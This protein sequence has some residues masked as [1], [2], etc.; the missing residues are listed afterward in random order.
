MYE[1]NLDSIIGGA[2]EAPA[3]EVEKEEVITLDDMLDG[4]TQM[5]MKHNVLS[6]VAGAISALTPNDEFTLMDIVLDAIGAD[7]EA[8]SIDEEAFGYATQ[9]TMDFAYALGMSESAVKDLFADDEMVAMDE[10]Q[11]FASAINEATHVEGDLA[12]LVTAH[13][14]M[15]SLIGQF[16]DEE[17]IEAG[18]MLDEITI[19]WAFSKTKSR[20][21][22]KTGTGH[23][24]KTVE[25]HRTIDGQSKKG[26][27][28][29]P[30]SLLSGKYKKA[31]GVS[32]KQKSHLAQMVTDAHT[33]V[34]QARRTKNMKL[35][36]G[37][38]SS[39][40]SK[41]SMAKA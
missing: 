20:K 28:R 16:A 19:D 27:C 3:V 37:G 1:I 26:F 21:K 5:H 18:V 2:V 24:M 38:R 33:S 40:V 11:N 15:D 4:M 29:Y 22:A 39:S 6:D 34:A 12:Q 25:C 41:A 8:D 30:K 7:V 14:H 17:E 9:V 13:L 31:K 36:R 23:T 35:T 10:V 32:S